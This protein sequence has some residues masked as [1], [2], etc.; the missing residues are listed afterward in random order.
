MYRIYVDASFDEAKFCGIGGALL[1]ME[2]REIA[3]FSEEV[4]HE[5]LVAIMTLG[6]RT[7]I[8]E[9]ETLAALAAVRLWGINYIHKQS[10]IV[11]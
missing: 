7:I 3:F 5:A 4:G 8:Q 9:L 10:C 11:H 2:G 1:D 6:Q